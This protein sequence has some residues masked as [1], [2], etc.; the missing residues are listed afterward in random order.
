MYLLCLYQNPGSDPFSLSLAPP[1]ILQPCISGKFGGQTCFCVIFRQSTTCSVVGDVAISK[2]INTN[3]LAI[4]LLLSYY[5]LRFQK[6][7]AAN[8]GSFDR[9]KPVYNSKRADMCISHGNSYGM[10]LLTRKIAITI[11]FMLVTVDA[12]Q[13][14][15]MYESL[16]TV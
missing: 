6:R 7:F 11:F 3:T 1:L 14:I 15:G 4:M 16:N 2:K 13:G 9:C 12:T 5:I 10:I 8:A